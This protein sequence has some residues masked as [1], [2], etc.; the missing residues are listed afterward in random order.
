[1]KILHILN[2]GHNTFAEQIIRTQEESNEVD[3]IDISVNNINYE[4]VV[5]AIFSNDLV[6][7]WS[8]EEEKCKV[9]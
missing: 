9:V 5:D 4:N 8:G 6:I 2:D 3:I 1:M 7:S